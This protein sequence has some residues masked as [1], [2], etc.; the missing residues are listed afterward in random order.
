M[1]GI[2]RDTLK[3]LTAEEFHRNL[4][5]MFD[6]RDSRHPVAQAVGNWHLSGYDGKNV[7]VVSRTAEIIGQMMGHPG[8]VVNRHGK[9]NALYSAIMLGTLYEAGP[10]R[11]EWD[12]SRE[13]PG[14]GNLLGAFLR[15]SGVEP[16]AEPRLPLAMGRKMRIECP[17]VDAKGNVLV[18]MISIN[19][20][21]LS[22]FE[23][24]LR[25][26]DSAPRPKMVLACVNGSR[27]MRP[28]PFALRDGR[29][30]AT[31][32]GFDTHATLL[33]LQDSGPLVSLD[34]TGVP[35]G[36]AGLLD[37]TPNARLKVQAVV[38]NPSPRELPA[39]PVRLY[40]ATGWSCDRAEASVGPIRPFGA[41]EASF[42]VVAPPLCAARN[43]R[44]LVV[45]YEAKTVTST[46]A[47][48]LVWWTPRAA[49][50]GVRR[51]PA[52]A[53]HRRP[54]HEPV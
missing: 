48:E 8:M 45:K 28:V 29:M 16:F 44:P 34:V 5:E 1:Y 19:D 13:G 6:Q 11:F 25:W 7:K 33:A 9:G 36:V 30:T 21:P 54:G 12:T 32:P 18:G 53:H 17:L 20:G 37:V 14:F 43:L 31:M 2:G 3:A 38:Y 41:A 49:R 52:P 24:S 23:V 35:R 27:W 39:G 51:D 40:A 15:F 10:V 4:D 42:E 46:P 47:T 26:P 22:P 50:P